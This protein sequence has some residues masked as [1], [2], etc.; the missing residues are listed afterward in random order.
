MRFPGFEG[1][2]TSNRLG[3]FAKFSKGKGISKIDI[4]ENGETECIRY[5]ELYTHYGEVIGEI[6]SKTSIDK[7]SLVLSE[8]N[9]V[10]IPASG[11]T[12]IDI[13]TAS[14]VLKAGVALGGDLNIIKTLN[15]G[16]FLSYYLNSKKKIDIARLS[17][18]ISV[19]HL[20]SSQLT[21]LSLNLPS[22]AEQHKIAMFLSLISDRISK[23]MKIISHLE[24]SI[25]SY[26]E[27]LFSQKFRFKDKLGY[28][29]ADWK[30]SKL[31]NICQKQSSNISA[32]KIEENFGSYT[33]YGASGILKKVDF[34]EE[35]NEF[36][37]IVKD[38]AGVG[39]LFLCE[40]KS[41]VLGTMD[42]IKPKP[43]VNIY[44]LFYQLSNIDFT[45]YVTGSTIP[46]I[47]FRDYKKVKLKI[48]SD[49]EQTKI[50]NFLFSI[51]E[52][53]EIEKK[54]L[55]QFE[56]QKKYLLTNLFV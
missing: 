42:I 38:G 17:Q 34:Y 11:E 53:I 26:R 10:V 54:I 9:D 14:C 2:W 52:K 44:F 12:Q 4:D 35:E 13:A 37:S 45:K 50:A 25:R 19:V 33:I 3:D 30:D 56:N 24:T 41:S 36:V 46:H 29:F 23:S 7:S 49:H 31:E 28:N 51:D 22:L 16:V 27:K 6:R 39:R 15:N 1:E 40:A 43:D 20:Y 8:G 21:L 48:P 32:N 18:G 47:Y 5:G 55:K